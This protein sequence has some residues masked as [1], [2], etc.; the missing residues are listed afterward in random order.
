MNK[1]QDIIITKEE[2]E[3]KYAEE[4]GLT[5]QQLYDSGCHAVPCNCGQDGCKGWRM[6]SQ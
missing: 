5:L 1:Q 6:A 3:I 4:S 2:F